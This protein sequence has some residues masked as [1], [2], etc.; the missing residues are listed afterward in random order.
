MTRKIIRAKI[1][2]REVLIRPENAD[3]FLLYR[4]D[5]ATAVSVD[6]RFLLALGE[7]LESGRVE[8]FREYFAMH[9]S[10]LGVEA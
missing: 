8:S 1:G 2:G 4:R 3:T 10:A 5:N 6:G 7:Y 9:L